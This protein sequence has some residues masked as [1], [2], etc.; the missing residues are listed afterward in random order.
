MI[1]IELDDEYEP[2][3]TTWQSL[4][5]DVRA[6]GGVLRVLMRDLRDLSGYQR[7]K[8]NVVA[9]ISERLR[10]IGLDHLPPDL[11]RD[12]NHGTSTSWFSGSEVR[13]VRSSM[14]YATEPGGWDRPPA[15]YSIRLS[16]SF[17]E[18]AAVSPENAYS[19]EFRS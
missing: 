19:Q 4:D 13:P 6:H 9:A 14:R 15:G 7:L 10:S 16:R 3:Y 11:P 12:R 1:A 5:E 18:S 2:K 17:S 8:V